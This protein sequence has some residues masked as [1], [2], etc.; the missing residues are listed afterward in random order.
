ML[1]LVI[2]DSFKAVVTIYILIPFLVIPQIIL[3]GVMVKFEKLNP[4]IS[5]PS[6]IPF[7]GEL[8]TARWGY[9]AL[10]VNQFIYN[11]FES[12]FYH[13]E[14]MRSQGFY[15]RN[16]WSSEMR[17]KLESVSNSLKRNERDNEFDKNLTLIRNEIRKELAF[18]PRIEFEYI[19]ALTPDKVTPEIIAT[20]QNYIELLR[21]YYIDYYNYADG[22]RN[23]LIEKLEKEEENTY[24]NLRDKYHNKALE[25][26]VLDKNET[27]T[28]IEYKGE[29]VQKMDPVFLDPQ[30]RFIKAHFYAPTKQVFGTYIDTYI[31]NIIILWVITIG[32]YFVLYFRLLKRAL[33]SGETLIGK[34]IK[35]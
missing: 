4:N 33:D 5:S 17:A 26:F 6:S 31:I 25:E 1:G 11:K 14:K 21:R 15:K 13:Y 29:F 30:H 28:L 9:E 27:T 8:I 19:D 32:L 24:L 10:A 2:S 3:S 12:R 18:T 22:K 35:E 16:F 7:Y 34:K 20:A 23:T